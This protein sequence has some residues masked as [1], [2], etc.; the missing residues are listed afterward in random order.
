MQWC[1]ALLITSMYIW[2]IQ[3]V[4]QIATSKPFS[5]NIKIAAADFSNRVAALTIF[6]LVDNLT[7]N[8][9]GIVHL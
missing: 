5:G 7:S 3:I 1:E 6:I 4:F 8:K 9:Y 2:K